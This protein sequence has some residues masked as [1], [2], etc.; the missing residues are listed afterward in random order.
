M[1]D[2]RA[3]EYLV[4]LARRYFGKNM[5]ADFSCFDMIFDGGDR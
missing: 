4:G 5:A 3:Y 1:R 2:G